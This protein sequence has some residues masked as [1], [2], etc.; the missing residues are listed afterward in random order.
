MTPAPLRILNIGL[1]RGLLP[2]A[3]DAEARARQAFYARSL[4]AELVHLVKAPPG[5]P[6]DRVDL[7]GGLSVVP[8]PVRHWSLFVPAALRAGAR[9][10][11]ESRFDLIQA[12]DPCICGLAGALL[13]RRFR[14]PLTVGLYSDEIDNPVWLAQGP[15]NRIANRVGKWVLRQ[16]A[17]ARSDSQ[18]V[19]D[20]LSGL[21][22]RNLVHI[23]FLI[24]HADRLRQPAAEAENLR[25]DLLAGETGP[26][27]LAVSRLEPEKNL[28]LMLSAFARA[29]SAQ[30]GAVLA[31]AGSGTLAEPLR[32]EAE[33]LAPGRVR[34]LGWMDNARI[35]ALFQSADLLLLS[36][37]RESAARVLYESALAGIPALSTDTAGAREAIADG[38]TGRVTPV[39]DAEAFADALSELCADPARLRRMGEAA[40]RH[41]ASLVSADAVIERM[42]RFYDTALGHTP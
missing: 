27:L 19:A 18:A 40:A 25:R 31:V 16:A 7:D 20:R 17:A 2:G 29:A 33:R 15:V 26:L 23:P 3:A 36:S 21:G 42:R 37:D 9:L 41:A 12:Q 38:E 28:P 35:P 10:L 4:P 11:R 30:A 24:T 6:C 32:R 8:C 34:W 13:A 1:D 39:G 22:I 14:L 5:T